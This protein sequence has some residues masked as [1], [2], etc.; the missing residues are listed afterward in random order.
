MLTT[1]HLSYYHSAD[2]TRG[3]AMLGRFPLADIIAA[4]ADEDNQSAVFVVVIAASDRAPFTLRANGATEALAWL[5]DLRRLAPRLALRLKAQSDPPSDAKMERRVG[6]AP[7][8]RL[9]AAPGAAAAAAMGP[10][11]ELRGHE[12]HAEAMH[13]RRQAR[14]RKAGAR[15]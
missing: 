1:N 4:H 13:A 5:V 6:T 15:P 9:N 7:S 8:G 2:D 12:L 14:R 10:D 3:H 11:P